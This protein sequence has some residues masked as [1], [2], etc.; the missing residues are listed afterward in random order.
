MA[1]GL[2]GLT[3]LTQDLLLYLLACHRFGDVL[4]WRFAYNVL[5][6]LE[7]RR[8]AFDSQLAGLYAPGLGLTWT[9]GSQRFRTSL[10]A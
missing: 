4:A 3:A 9:L 8:W 7:R 1:R 2:D 10:W 5:L 6:A